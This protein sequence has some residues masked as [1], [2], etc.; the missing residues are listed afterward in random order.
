MVFKKLVI[1]C[2][3][4]LSAIVTAPPSKGHPVMPA[5]TRGHSV[6]FG[7]GSPANESLCDTGQ[8]T[9]LFEPWF[10]YLQMEIIMYISNVISVM[11]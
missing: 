1:S 5:A 11:F 7:S 9:L 8:V 6:G 3:F 10:L 2:K 4:H